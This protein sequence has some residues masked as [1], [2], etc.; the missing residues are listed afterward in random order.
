MQRKHPATYRHRPLCLLLLAFLFLLWLVWHALS[1]WRLPVR[2]RPRRSGQAAA[3]TLPSLAA[4]LRVYLLT[5]ELS[6]SGAPRVCVELAQLLQASGARVT[7]VVGEGFDGSLPSDAEL[8]ARAGRLLGSAPAFAV[9]GDRVARGGPWWQW[10]RSLGWVG[11]S[12]ELQQAAAADV[13]VVSTA[14]PRHI[15]WLAD[16]RALA[17]GHGGLLWWVHEGATVMGQFPPHVTRAAADAQQRPGLLNALV[18]PSHSTLAWWQGATAALQASGQL[19]PPPPALSLP[20]PAVVHWGW[21]AWR[22]QQPLPTGAAAAQQRQALGLAPTDFVFLTLAAFTPLKGHPG[23]VRAF[24]RAQQ[25]CGSGSSSSSGSGSG[26]A[27]RLVLAGDNGRAEAPFFSLGAQDPAIQLLPPHSSPAALLG[28]ADAYVSNT[29]GGGETWGLAILDALGS[30]TPVL[31]S[32]TGAVGEMLE[33]GSTALLHSVGEG[34][35]ASG[36]EEAEELAGNMC[37]VVGEEGLRQGLAARGRAHVA[38]HFGQQQMEAQL[39]Q[40]LAALLA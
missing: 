7:L 14:I 5:H 18:F 26:R 34:V 40:A 22:A 8:V 37:R 2:G 36:V 32:R 6:L 33:H 11:D 30:G 21:P 29:Q 23:I 28:A 17:P 20:A 10:W 39:V 16:F 38:L 24:Q 19:P 25:L 3:R 31:A 27:L 12:W 9:R 15:A 1:L 4:G 13:V 35:S